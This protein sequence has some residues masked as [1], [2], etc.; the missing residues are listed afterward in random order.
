MIRSTAAAVDLP[1]P[2]GTTSSTSAANKPTKVLHMTT[3]VGTGGAERMLL[4]LIAD[5]DPAEYQ[6]G[7][8]ALR[9][10]GKLA[11]PIRDAGA[12][13]WNCGL[14][15]GDLSPRAAFDIRRIL[16]EF[17][18]D[19]VQ[20]WM[21]HGNL[22]ACLTK[23]YSRKVPIFWGI[24]HTI[25]DINNEKR[26]TR[27]SIR[28]GAKLSK[29]PHGIVYVSRMSREQHRALGYYDGAASTIPNGFD[30][31]K[32]KP[33]P[34]ARAKLRQSLGLDGD[35]LILAK[36]AVVRPMKDHGNLLRAASL[37]KSRGQKFTLL[38]I[39][40]RA[41]EDN[42]ELMQLADE[43]DVRD[44]VTF[45]GERHDIPDIMPG[46]DGLVVSSGWGEAFPIVLGEAMA[47][48]LPCITTDVGDSAY[49]VGDT[50]LVVSPRD[51]EA[52]ASA[53]AQLLG[54]DAGE[55][56]RLA[57]LARKRIEENFALASVGERY[58]QLYR[59]AVPQSVPLQAVPAP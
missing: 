7:V 3:T 27:A 52:L 31:D 11:D 42:A 30:C 16:S 29:W 43:A 9:Q 58:Y 10:D 13:L 21:Y 36:I 24:H 55:R 18:P 17:R 44:C 56:S 6:H 45:L 34:E 38:V 32:F 40:Q 59:E 26:L 12:K 28:L 49:L 37:L 22:A 48:G 1:H 33:K 25:D 19:V 57:A 23:T 20:G 35:A 4:N 2:S 39:G 15:A 5:S 51:A 8:I 53:M 47:S 14:A 41:T 46:L 54:M 50:G